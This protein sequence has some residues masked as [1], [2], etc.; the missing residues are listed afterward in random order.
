MNRFITC[1][2]CGASIDLKYANEHVC[3]EDDDERLRML[4]FD[5]SSFE[6]LDDDYF[7]MLESGVDESEEDSWSGFQIV[8]TELEAL[9]C[10]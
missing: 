3:Y 7:A 5:E 9:D 10:E 2:N 6:N 1:E 4:N 8:S